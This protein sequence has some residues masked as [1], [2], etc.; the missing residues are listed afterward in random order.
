MS[1][2]HT[3]S[4]IQ[5][6]TKNV[7]RRKGWQSLQP[8]DL[9]WA[10]PRI[11]GL[12]R[13]QKVQRLALLRCLSIRSEPLNR[14]TSRDVA[15]EGYPGMKPSEFVQM[16]CRDMGGTPDQIVQRIEFAYEEEAKA[17]PM[18]RPIGKGAVL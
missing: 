15:R 13:G 2:A 3:T 16:F 5:D 18:M 11:R 12:K 6:R 1:F 7:T 17:P 14:V 9:F 4:K 10:C 8:G